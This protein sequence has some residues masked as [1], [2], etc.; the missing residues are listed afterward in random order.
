[1]RSRNKAPRFEEIILFEKKPKKPLLEFSE[2]DFE[3]FN[4]VKVIKPIKFKRKK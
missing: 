2:E 1:M 3:E 4:K